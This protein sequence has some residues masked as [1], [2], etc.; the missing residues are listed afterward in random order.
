MADVDVD[1]D[2]ASRDPNTR[3][4]SS[5]SGQPSPKV[6]VRSVSN[7][8][9]FPATNCRNCGRGPGVMSQKYVESLQD[10]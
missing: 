10:R 6:L 9:A 4:E 2:A 3:E 8:E 1:E 5:S 7:R